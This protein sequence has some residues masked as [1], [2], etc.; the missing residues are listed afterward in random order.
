MADDTKRSATTGRQILTARLKP[1]AVSFKTA[2]TPVTA[3]LSPKV[4]AGLTVRPAAP[5]QIRIPQPAPPLI[6][7][8]PVPPQPAPP[9]VVP[10]A[11]ADNPFND[12][13]MPA[14]GDRIKADDF[15]KLSQGLRTIYDAYLLSGALFGRSYGEA[16]LALASQ[17]YQ[18]EM[19]MTVFGNAIADP[20]DGSLDSRR[21][22]Q[23]VPLELGERR[24]AL[25]LT[26]AVETRRFMPNLLELSYKEASERLQALLGDAALPGGPLPAPQFVGHSLAEAKQSTQK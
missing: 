22:I 11:S 4:L 24:V 19:A 3:T 21:V 5:P 14:P 12:L 25:V 1:Q 16:R 18:I 15:K 23:V 13:P 8:Q 9:P 17:A 2:T 10:A 6:A 20:N 7:P 26:E